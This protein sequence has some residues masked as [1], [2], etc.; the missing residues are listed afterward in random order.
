MNL[1]DEVSSID[2]DV[3]NYELDTQA[4]VNSTVY[5]MYAEHARWRHVESLGIATALRESGIGPI[6]M[7]LTIK[8]HRELRAGD[9]VRITTSFVDPGGASKIFFCEQRMIKPDNTLVAEVRSTGGLLDLKTRRLIACPRQIL[10]DLANSP[11]QG[12]S[13]GL[14]AA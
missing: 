6:F 8:Y 12:D 3:R 9:T 4:H 5:L 2:I 11:R 10:E 1:T 13:Q 14:G 7:E